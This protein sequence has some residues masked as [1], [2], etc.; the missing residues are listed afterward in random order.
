M[1][2]KVRNISLRELYILGILDE[3]GIINYPKYREYKRKQEQKGIKIVL[4]A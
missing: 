2:L 1:I 3:N 4:N